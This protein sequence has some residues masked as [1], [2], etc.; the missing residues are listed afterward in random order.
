MTKILKFIRHHGWLEFLRRFKLIIL[1]RFFLI[2]EVL[3][4]G[5]TSI[6]EFDE[7][8]ISS[9]IELKKSDIEKM[10]SVMYLSDNDIVNR[11]NNGDKCYAIIDDKKIATYIWGHFKN[12]W[13]EE[14]ELEFNLLDNQTWLYNVVT[15]REARGKGYYTNILRYLAKH[16]SENGFTEI[17]GYAEKRNFPSIKGLKK[18]G[19][20]LV[21]KIR[22]KKILL[23]TEYEVSVIDKNSWNQLKKTIV[24]FE[25]H[26]WIVV[27]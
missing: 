23:K 7:G 5:A 22:L 15:V 17:Y 10:L 9:I 19:Y 3:I 27:N 13:M 8:S 26:K 11:F 25:K 6:T 12:H 20:N 1:K 21:L 2:R 24:D 18:A 14:L 4:F 16:L